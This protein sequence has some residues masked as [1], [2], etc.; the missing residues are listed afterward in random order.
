M[1][2][3]MKVPLDLGTMDENPFL[4]RLTGYCSLEIYILPPVMGNYS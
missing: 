4:E 2:G 1:R 3:G